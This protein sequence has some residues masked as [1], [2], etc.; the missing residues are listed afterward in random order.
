MDP[1]DPRLPLVERIPRAWRNTLL[2]LLPSVAL[3]T[4]FLVARFTTDSPVLYSSP[5]DHFKYGST[6]GE[7][8][9]GFP[10]W[11]WKALPSLFPEHLPGGA[12]QADT[13]YAPLGFLYEKNADG[14]YKDLRIGVSRRNV[15]GLDRVFLTCAIC[16]A[17]TVRATA[18]STP[19]VVLGMPSNT[20]DLQAFQRFIFASA[21]DERFTAARILGEIKKM[22]GL[23]DLGRLNERALRKVGITLMR[24]RLL[25]LRH[26]FQFVDREPD[27]GPGRVDTF[28]AP[29]VLLNFRMDLLPERE[30]VGNCDFPSIW[31]QAP[32]QGMRL[33][34]DGNNDKV[35]ERNRSA[36][37]GTGSYPPTLDRPAMRRVE[38][39]LKT[40]AARVQGFLQ[41]GSREAAGRSI[42]HYSRS[43]TPS[44][45]GARTFTRP[46]VPN[47]MA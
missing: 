33:H 22:D 15:Q 26:R 18:R 38:D 41:S 40:L 42:G 37:F 6:G 16:H 13:P 34:W 4:L 31:L 36:A 17:G 45:P 24:D 43:T 27:F 47:A 21:T 20:V 14:T 12:Y 29:K 25:L 30:W 19:R 35:E 44:R 32:K 39:W 3:A 10:Y 2:V 23:R 5:E 9:S 46:I 7:R 11:V 1:S 8:A 28:N